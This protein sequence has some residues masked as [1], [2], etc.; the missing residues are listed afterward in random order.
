MDVTALLVGIGLGVVLLW[1]TLV[2]ALAITKPADA[3][4]TEVLRLLPDTVVLLRRFAG[5]PDLPR[6]VRIRLLLLLAYMLLPI[7]LIPDFIPVVGFADDAIIVA[8]ALRSVVRHAGPEAL[9]AHWPGTPRGLDAV[10]RLAGIG[11]MGQ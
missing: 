10:K 4:L 6:G 8:V 5:D 9:D 2:I 7:D 3:N 1:V 11:K